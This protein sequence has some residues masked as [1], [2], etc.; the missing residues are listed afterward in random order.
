MGG[1]YKRKAYCSTFL[2]NKPHTVNLKRNQQCIVRHPINLPSDKTP[3]FT[4]YLTHFLVKLIHDLIYEF[5]LD[6]NFP[7]R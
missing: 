1:E 7:I 4:C 2:S 3:L 5:N 6:D